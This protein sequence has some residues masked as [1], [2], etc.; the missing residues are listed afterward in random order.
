[1]QSFLPIGPL[2]NSV[3]HLEND[4]VATD[5]QQ[6][7]PL[8]DI[9]RAHEFAGIIGTLGNVNLVRSLRFRQ[10]WMNP[11][12]E[13]F[14]APAGSRFRVTYNKETLARENANYTLC[15]SQNLLL[16]L[17]V[18]SLFE[19]RDFTISNTLEKPSSDEQFQ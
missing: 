14:P 4:P 13:G 12:L 8:I 10:D 6:A 11:F 2:E 3:H 15:L 1:M 7:A 5:H 17:I 19:R 16:Y 9:L 18:L